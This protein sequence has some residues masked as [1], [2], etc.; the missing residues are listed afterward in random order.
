M[1]ENA[2]CAKGLKIKTVQAVRKPP[3]YA[4]RCCWENFGE[5]EKRGDSSF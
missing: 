2:K 4:L 5:N 1:Q 3:E